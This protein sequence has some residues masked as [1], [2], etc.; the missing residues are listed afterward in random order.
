[1]PITRREFIQTAT[2]SAAAIPLAIRAQ[3]SQGDSGSRLFRHGVASGDPLTDRVMLWTRVSPPET[4][5]FAPIE[6]GWQIA[7]DEALTQIVARGSASTAEARDY[8]V[9]VDAGGLRPGRIYY[10]AFTVGG[11]RSPVGRTK[12]LPERGNARLRLASVSCS[13]YP[14][15]YFNV[16]RCIAN[17]PDLD[18][19]VHLGDYIYEFA[20]G[21][22]GDGTA[23]GRVPIP[24]GEAVTLEDY[25]HR[26]A[27]YRSDIDLQ[28]AHRVHPFIVV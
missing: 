20:N 18:A 17:R 8:T 7:S 4:R 14:A 27:T 5:A 25:R 10:Y 23:A 11:E 22:F 16:Y 21:R 9:K 2:V 12:T 1:M 13:N 6:V 3:Q 15:G 24:R 19:V 28:E 26:Y